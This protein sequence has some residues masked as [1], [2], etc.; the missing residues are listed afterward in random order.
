MLAA[1]DDLQY[2][3]V[4]CD[5]TPQDIKPQ[6]RKRMKQPGVERSHL[7]VPYVMRIE[8]LVIKARGRAKRAHDAR[9]VVF[10]FL[11]DVFIDDL[12][13]GRCYSIFGI[14]G[15]PLPRSAPL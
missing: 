6:P 10:V 2:D 13:T 12:K 9:E 11:S 14:H 5:V 1:N 4:D 8:G 3:G 15:H 7:V